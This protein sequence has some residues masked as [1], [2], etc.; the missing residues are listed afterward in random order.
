M[1][2]HKSS[3]HIHIVIINI[4]QY[5]KSNSEKYIVL[6]RFSTESIE[7]VIDEI[8][9]KHPKNVGVLN[10]NQTKIEACRLSVNSCESRGLLAKMNKEIRSFDL[11]PVTFAAWNT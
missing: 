1:Q 6:L 3:R 11:L 10:A 2:L 7:C 9:S 8:I 5:I 4:K